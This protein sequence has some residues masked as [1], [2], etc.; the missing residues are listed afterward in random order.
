MG[1]VGPIS[2]KVELEEQTEPR[3][4]GLFMRTD[5]NRS[6]GTEK[7]WERGF[8]KVRREVVG[9]VPKGMRRIRF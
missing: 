2:S 8:G 7:R 1:R 4:L 6:I 9:Q 3:K 5:G